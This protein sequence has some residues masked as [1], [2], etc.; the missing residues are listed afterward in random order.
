M[1]I[2]S[3][4][5]ALAVLSCV[6]LAQ[7]MVPGHPG[8]ST[9]NGPFIPMVTTPEVSLTTVSPDPVGASNATYGLHAGATNSTLSLENVNGNVGGSYTQPVWYAG[10]TTPLISTPA[11]ELSVPVARNMYIP[12]REPGREHQAGATQ[13]WTY[14]AAEEETASPVAASAA[15]R[16]GKPPARTITNQDVEQVNQKNGMVK[17]DNKTEQIK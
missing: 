17:Y 16:T 13:S 9:C 3:I 10:G 7:T 14:Y 6:A 1:R 5:C 12:R 2:F 15:A 4:S 8:Y 11:V